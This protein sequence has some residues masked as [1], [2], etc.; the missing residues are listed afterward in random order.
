MDQAAKEVWIRFHDALGRALAA[1]DCPA[2]MKG[3]MVKFRG[4]ALRLA[5][6]LHLLRHAT[7]ECMSEDVDETSLE[8][9]VTL[10]SYFLTHAERVHA[11]MNQPAKGQ[12]ESDQSLIQTIQKLLAHNQGTWK[13]KPEHLLQAL[14]SLA[15]NEMQH[16]SHWPNSPDSLGR[17]VR[18]ITITAKNQGIEIEW[19]KEKNKNRDRFIAI[20]KKAS[21]ASEVSGGG[22]DTSDASD[23]FRQESN[24]PGNGFAGKKTT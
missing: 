11:A 16:R 15:T 18:R 17:I 19:G 4:Y 23:A 3:T 8:R 10:V 5:L 2:N 22:L 12:A 9:A 20:Y 14:N 7:G 21:E 24:P 6:I 1:S 13:G